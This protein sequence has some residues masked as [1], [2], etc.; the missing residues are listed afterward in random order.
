MQCQA[1]WRKPNDD[2]D[3]VVSGYDV[4]VNGQRHARLFGGNST[5]A[6]FQV[7]RGRVVFERGG[8]DISTRDN[9][10]QVG[11]KQ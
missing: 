6:Q 11:A 10:R 3:A 4:L 7:N 9:P 1:S 8:V 5:R 2:G